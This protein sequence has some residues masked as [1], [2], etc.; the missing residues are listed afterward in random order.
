MYISRRKN[1]NNKWGLPNL[2]DQF[3]AIF[4]IIRFKWKKNK[5]KK[6][7]NRTRFPSLKTYGKIGQATIPIQSSIK[8]DIQ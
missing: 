2:F 3:I 5:N 4:D 6:I 1:E 8:V 7:V